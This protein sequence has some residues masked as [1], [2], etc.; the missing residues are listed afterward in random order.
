MHLDVHAVSESLQ[1]KNKK[2]TNMICGDSLAEV[3]TSACMHALGCTCRCDLF[4]RCMISGYYIYKIEAVD[5]LGSFLSGCFMQ[6]AN[7]PLSLLATSCKGNH[8]VINLFLQ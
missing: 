8:S 6:L 4:Q 1:K 2:K 7:K 3:T 5:A